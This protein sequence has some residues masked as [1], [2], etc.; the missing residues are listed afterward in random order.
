[1]L[2]GASSQDGSIAAALPR[3]AMMHRKVTATVTLAQQS[4]PMVFWNARPKAHCMLLLLPQVFCEMSSAFNNVHVA[5]MVTRL[6]KVCV[7]RGAR[8]WGEVGVLTEHCGT[9]LLTKAYGP[10]IMVL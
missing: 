7:Q 2:A 9:L 8:V 5:A 3:S 4:L 10:V 6:P 1:M